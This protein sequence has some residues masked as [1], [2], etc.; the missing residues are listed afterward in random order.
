MIEF[1]LKHPLG[2]SSDHIVPKS[3]GGSNKLRNRLLAHQD[4]N[5]AK[6][7]VPP[8][9]L[10]NGVTLMVLKARAISRLN[11]IHRQRAALAT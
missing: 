2:V 5:S 8:I 7:D 6:A 4:C 3:K 1:L 9:E 11:E 10:S